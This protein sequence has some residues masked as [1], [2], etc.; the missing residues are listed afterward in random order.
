MMRGKEISRR[1]TGRSKKWKIIDVK[2][3]K[4]PVGERQ[5]GM[6]LYR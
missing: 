4:L 2:R 5:R 6:R 3:V 1:E